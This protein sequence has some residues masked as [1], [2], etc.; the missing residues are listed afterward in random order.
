MK[1]FTVRYDVDV[2]GGPMVVSIKGDFRSGVHF[3][4]IEDSLNLTVEMQMEPVTIDLTKVIFMDSDS[5]N[6]IKSLEAKA[7]IVWDKTSHVYQIYAQSM[8]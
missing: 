2:F 7:N 4:S 3:S 5:M 6:L 8:V 1:P